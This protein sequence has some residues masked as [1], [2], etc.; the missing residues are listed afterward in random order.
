MSGAQP[1]RALLRRS[2]L[3]TSPGDSP[4]ITKIGGP[5]CQHA[6]P[7][8]KKIDICRAGG[9]D[10]SFECLIQEFGAV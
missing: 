6:G 10:P 9:N 5:L 4:S 3:P 1:E 7:P 2:N 8:S